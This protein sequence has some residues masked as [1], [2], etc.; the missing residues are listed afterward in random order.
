MDIQAKI[1]NEGTEEA[2]VY[3]RLTLPNVVTTA[4]G[5]NVDIGMIEIISEEELLA[6]K[7]SKLRE[8]DV[9]DAKLKAIISVKPVTEEI[10]PIKKEK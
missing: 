3:Y 6:Q 4:Y 9:I 5:Q 1:H 7:D 10:Q 8:I 2:P